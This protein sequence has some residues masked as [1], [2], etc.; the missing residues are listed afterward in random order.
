MTRTC[1]VRKRKRK[2]K[3]KEKREKR[4]EKREKRKNNMSSDVQLGNVAF[5]GIRFREKEP[6]TKRLFSKCWQACFRGYLRN[7][8]VLVAHS[9]SVVPSLVGTHGKFQVAHVMTLFFCWLLD[10]CTA[11]GEKYGRAA[12]SV[13]SSSTNKTQENLLCV[14]QTGHLNRKV[15]DTCNNNES[16]C[17][18]RFV[19][20]RFRVVLQH[21]LVI[22]G[23]TLST[24]CHA[25]HCSCPS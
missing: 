2:R 5:Q 14:V 6:L 15:T 11:G 21:C 17:L 16:K 13:K 1:Q 3:R 18:S 22:W 9:V 24:L 10:G 8:L 23:F 25:Q 12:I 7:V 19:L 20:F 4:K